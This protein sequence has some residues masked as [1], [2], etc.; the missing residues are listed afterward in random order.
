MDDPKVFCDWVTTPEGFKVY[1]CEYKRYKKFTLGKKNTKIGEILNF[2]IPPDTVIFTTGE[3]VRTCPGATPWC[4]RHCYAKKKRF[5]WRTTMSSLTS[6]LVWYFELGPYRF[7]ERLERELRK[8]ETRG[9]EKTLRLH[10]A[11][12]FFEKD[13]I[14]M[15]RHIAER[16][17]DWRFYT[18]TRSWRVPELLPYLEKLRRL[19]NFVLYASTDPD[20]GPPPPGW[21]EACCVDTNYK[22][23]FKPYTKTIRC[24][25]EVAEEKAGRPILPC[26]KCRVC[27]LG[28][29][30]VH[31]E[32]IR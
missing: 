8:A 23:G 21:L 32:V 6:R 18:Y 12:D 10:V 4:R 26:K 25:G 27:I 7:A 1:K 11:G 24:P 22:P 5:E 29:A 2:S 28:S 13:Y 15:W 19:P 16:M 14:E 3:V 9:V 20:T 30:S 17:P 31:W